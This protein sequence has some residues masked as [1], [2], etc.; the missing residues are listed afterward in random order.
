[1]ATPVK[2]KSP[3]GN[4]PGVTNVGTVGAC[5]GETGAAETKSQRIKEG[6]RVFSFFCGQRKL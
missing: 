1:M 3:N 4:I 6:F 5:I 2:T